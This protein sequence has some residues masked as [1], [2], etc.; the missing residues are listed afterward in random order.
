[1]CC[2]VLHQQQGHQQAS[3]KRPLSPVAH[4]DVGFKVL[5]AVEPLLHWVYQGFETGLICDHV[6]AVLHLCIPV[7]VI[8]WYNTHHNKHAMQ[9][10]WKLLG[11]SCSGWHQEKLVSGECVVIGPRVNLAEAIAGVVR[12][13]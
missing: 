8:T 2:L 6:A 1:M 3:S 13:G 11:V 4:V 7:V 5:A 10:V 12:L 9:F